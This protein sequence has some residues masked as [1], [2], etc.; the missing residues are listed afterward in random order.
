L[1][2][3]PPTIVQAVG[4]FSPPEFQ[5]VAELL[6]AHCDV[7]FD[8]TLAGACER[9][10]H[11]RR[12]PEVVV[13]A[14]CRPGEISAN[15]LDHLQQVAPLARFIGLLGPWCE[16]EARSGSPWPGMLRTY[17]HQWTARYAAEL[18]DTARLPG[19]AISTGAAPEDRL[20]TQP[21]FSSATEPGVIA[22]ISRVHAVAD[23]L[24]DACASFGHATCMLRGDTSPPI[25]E[26]T[27]TSF[28]EATGT[29][30]REATMVIWNGRVDEIGDFQRLALRFPDVP[31]LASIDFP[32]HDRIAEFLDT[33]ACGVLSMPF[34]LQDL[35]WHLERAHPVASGQIAN[36]VA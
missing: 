35:R 19:W 1:S 28:R 5:P 9:V 10:F 2:A 30:I 36:A 14:Q 18:L 7:T 32:R 12:F 16:G 23:M 17:W 33:G 31:I 15:E 29:S 6:R 24:A 22:V 25:R 4:D 11:S 8:H 34:L 3:N 26:A 20:L 21:A 27:G 13:V